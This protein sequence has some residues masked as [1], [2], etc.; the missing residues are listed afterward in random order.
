MRPFDWMQAALKDDQLGPMH[1]LL[2]YALATHTYGAPGPSCDATWAQLHEW[3]GMTRRAI[4]MNLNR[5]VERGWIVIVR[6]RAADGRQASSMYLLTLPESVD[7]SGSNGSQP[8][9]QSASDA[10]IR[11]H[12]MHSGEHGQSASDAPLQEGTKY[13]EA[14]PHTTT[15]VDNVVAYLARRKGMP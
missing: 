10:P 3:T 7:K 9:V 5:I 2:V 14:N 1:K 6:R 12:V 4:P 13:L 11:V 8:K 15:P